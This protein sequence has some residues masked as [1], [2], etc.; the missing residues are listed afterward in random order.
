[1]EVLSC[2][3]SPCC[4]SQRLAL[5]AHA[6]TIEA[7]S[8]PAQHRLCRVSVKDKQPVRC[9]LYPSEEFYEPTRTKACRER[10]VAFSRAARTT[11]SLASND[12]LIMIAARSS[13]AS[14]AVVNAGAARKEIEA[15]AENI[16][17]KIRQ[18]TA[19]LS[20]LPRGFQ[21]RSQPRLSRFHA[22]L[23]TATNK[24]S[25]NDDIDR[26]VRSEIKLTAEVFTDLWANKVGKEPEK[27]KES[28]GEKDNQADPESSL[29]TTQAQQ[30]NSRG[31][32]LDV[33]AAKHEQEREV[34]QTVQAHAAAQSV[35]EGSDKGGEQPGSQVSRALSCSFHSHCSF[36]GSPAADD[37][38]EVFLECADAVVI[39]MSL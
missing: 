23:I 24:I 25:S 15:L 29:S 9:P 26:E 10:L 33:N 11:Q 36:S 22:S 21:A 30:T 6:L 34:A 35:I 28:G 19:E 2:C 32:R 13:I 39:T 1:M 7:Q 37:G 20:Q 31:L 17:E 38:C 12:H 3:I 5:S 27:E 18:A 16:L 8:R 14:S 4:Y